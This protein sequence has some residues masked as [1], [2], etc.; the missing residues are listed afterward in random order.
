MNQEKRRALAERIG[1]RTHQIKAGRLT[2][3]Q[4]TQIV[5]LYLD[6]ET[7]SSL[8]RRFGVSPQTIRHHLLKH[9]KGDPELEAIAAGG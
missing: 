8:A 3:A 5:D 1:E 9:I 6:G 4:R 7:Q 2:E